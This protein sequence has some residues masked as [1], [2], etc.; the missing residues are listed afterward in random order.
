MDAHKENVIVVHC[1]GGKGRTGTMIAAWLVRAGLFQQ[2]EKSLA[3]F[4]DRRTDSSKGMK[5]Q[6]VDT[7]S[8]VGVAGGRGHP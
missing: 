8:Q 6:G 1:K 3:Y 5:S 4:R 2:A 7:P